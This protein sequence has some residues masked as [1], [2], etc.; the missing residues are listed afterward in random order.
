MKTFL[1]HLQA[2]YGTEDE[3]NYILPRLTE[4]EVKSCVKAYTR[5]AIVE[6]LNR[7]AENAQTEGDD[8]DTAY[9]WIKNQ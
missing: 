5:E 8:M 7:A 6:H 4:L 3:M 1:Q 2:K 9:M